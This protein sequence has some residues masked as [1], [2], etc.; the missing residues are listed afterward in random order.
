MLDED[1]LV[2]EGAAG[3]LRASVNTLLEAM[4]QLLSNVNITEAPQADDEGEEDEGEREEGWRD[5]D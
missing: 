5:D 2:G 3:N 4:R 1:E